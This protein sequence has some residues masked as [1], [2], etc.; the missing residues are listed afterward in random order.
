MKLTGLAIEAIKAS[1]SNTLE[2]ALHLKKTQRRME[3]LLEQNKPN[4]LL[5]TVSAVRKIEE[6]TGLQESQVLEE[7]EPA[8]TRR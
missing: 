2:L 4:N 3:Q 8:H 5:T 6:L 7:A 1:P